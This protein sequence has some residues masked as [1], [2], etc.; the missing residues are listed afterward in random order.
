MVDTDSDDEKS[1]TS[2]E[3][4]KMK[5]DVAALKA[6]MDAITKQLALLVSLS[7]GS[8]PGALVTT[9]TGTGSAIIP[10]EVHWPTLE[11]Q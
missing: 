3:R 1:Q 8:N 5:Q 4:R 10:R 11:V 2:S 7:P 6:S 9:N